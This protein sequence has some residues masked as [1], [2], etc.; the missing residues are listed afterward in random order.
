MV[1]SA[2]VEPQFSVCNMELMVPTALGV[3]MGSV[4]PGTGFPGGS[5]DKKTTRLP[6]QER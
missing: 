5:S 2:W 4:R 6:M 3:F 1:K